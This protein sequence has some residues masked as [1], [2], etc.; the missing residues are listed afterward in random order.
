MR[1]GEHTQFCSHPFAIFMTEIFICI[2]AIKWDAVGTTIFRGEWGHTSPENCEFKKY[3]FAMAYFSLEA[4]ISTTG[5]TLK[6]VQ[7]EQGVNYI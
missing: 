7:S 2:L 4:G 3:E 5:K 1:Q 6:Q